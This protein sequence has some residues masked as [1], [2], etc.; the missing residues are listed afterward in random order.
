MSED[1]Q[2]LKN[3]NGYPKGFR[4]LFILIMVTWFFLAMEVLIN[5]LNSQN[6]GRISLQSD[7]NVKYL[8]SI[9]LKLDMLDKKVSYME[10][11]IEGFSKELDLITKNYLDKRPGRA[12]EKDKISSNEGDDDITPTANE[13]KE[14]EE[15][16]KKFE[17]MAYEQQ[18]FS[19]GLADLEQQVVKVSDS[20]QKAE[21]N[22]RS[23]SL[24][25]SAIHLRDAVYNAKDYNRE[26]DTLQMFAQG[27]PLI[28]DN[29]SILRP[30]AKKGI[31]SMDKVKAD[32]DKLA[33]K[34]TDDARQ[35]KENPGLFDMA[36]MQF[37]KVV[38]VRKIDPEA[39]GNDAEDII[40]RTYNHLL[41]SDI[42]AAVN[43]MKKLKGSA[44]IMAEEWIKMAESVLDSRQAAEKIFEYVS[45]PSYGSDENKGNAVN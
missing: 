14:R 1:Q 18:A 39:E 2:N 5:N 36:A 3:E 38:T 25:I 31:A 34:I 30:N 33:G 16:A 27:D 7:D 15:T 13:T 44:R 8:A 20:L 4:I 12:D 40:A 45:M 21:S 11:R 6:V 41:D 19:S 22:R 43:D 9:Q 32:F 24:V 42:A 37:A 28:M 17:K 10:D 23:S 29:F 26:L 35:T